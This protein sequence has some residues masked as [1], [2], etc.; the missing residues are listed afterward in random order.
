[1]QHVFIGVDVSKDHLDIHHPD[2]GTFRIANDTASIDK[3]ATRWHRE[4]VQVIFEATGGYERCLCDTLERAGVDYSRVNPRQARAFARAMGIAAKT[5]KVD[6][7]MLSAF[8]KH[9]M[10]AITAPVSPVRRTL[11][12]L[13]ARRRQLVEMR[14]QETTRLAQTT[15]RWAQAD[16]KSLLAILDRRI[17][18]LEI[19]IA[20]HVGGDAEMAHKA[21][22]LQTAPG[23]G[24]I[25]A[26]TLL[27]EL[28]EL[29]QLNRRAIAAL[30]GLAPL[31][32]DSG[33]HTG[34]RYLGGGRPQVRSMLYIA[35][36]QASRHCLT[37]TA[38]RTR[39]QQA[40]K[41]TKL[42][43]AATAHKL[44]TVLNAMLRDNKNFTLS[45][46]G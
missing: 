15:N 37:F 12:G 24:P 7:R 34:K 17:R 35:G 11:H 38:F 18:K 19:L 23:V 25:V 4:G 43:L 6:A 16:I 8:G 33:K 41:P 13:V 29:G 21:R 9:L 14:K 31:A 3:S 2:H 20:E 10:P 39:L 5:D 45:Q 40:G 36:L 42:A 1:M 27:S 32:R 44:L 22:Q 30:A 26:A 28:P 46:S